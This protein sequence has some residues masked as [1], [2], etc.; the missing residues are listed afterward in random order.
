M[1]LLKPTYKKETPGRR[2]NT[3]TFLP[4]KVY[5]GAGEQLLETN[6]DMWHAVLMGVWLW[7]AGGPL[8]YGHE[9]G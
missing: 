3:V 5:P 1:F 4:R 2:S 8:R 9:E 6:I 7:V